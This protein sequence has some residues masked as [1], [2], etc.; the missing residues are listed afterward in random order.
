MYHFSAP[1]EVSLKPSDELSDPL[2]PLV[3]NGANAPDAGEGDEGE[4][5]AGGCCREVW[6]W[7]V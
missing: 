3:C 5:G 4:Y 7:P 1:T 2:L 6:K